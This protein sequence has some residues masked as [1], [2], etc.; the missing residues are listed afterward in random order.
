MAE[1]RL[2]KSLSAGGREDRSSQDLSRRPAEEKFASTQES[3]KAWSDEWTQS[4]LPKLAGDAIPGWHLCWLSTTNSYDSIDKR[5]RLG[6]VPV[7]ADELPGFDS[8]RVKAGEH[9][10]F[11]SCNEMLLFKL[12]MEIYQ[13]VMTKFH[14]TAPQEEAQKIEVQLENLQGQA[15]DSANRR[16]L[17][18]EGEGF[19]RIDKQQ[20][21]SAPIFEG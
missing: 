9:T 11:I 3:L 16:L 17:Q 8:F 18:V 1:S 10:G 20:P 13:A 14:H 2:K 4:A 12:P 19:G 21:T 6:Y 15:R 5:M 7:K